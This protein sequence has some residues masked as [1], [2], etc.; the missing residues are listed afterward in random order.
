MKAPTEHELYQVCWAVGGWKAPVAVVRTR[1]SA[2]GLEVLGRAW[3][4]SYVTVRPG[5]DILTLGARGKDLIRDK[6]FR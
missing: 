1:L 4:L 2:R 6:M 5:E 3:D